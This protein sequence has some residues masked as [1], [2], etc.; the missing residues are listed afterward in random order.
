MAATTTATPDHHFTVDSN[1][2][3]Q[4]MVPTFWGEVL[5]TSSLK[6]IVEVLDYVQVWWAGDRSRCRT[7]VQQL[8]G[9]KTKMPSGHG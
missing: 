2:L 4:F 5:Y 6:H 3:R 8:K 7:C 9:G 1:A